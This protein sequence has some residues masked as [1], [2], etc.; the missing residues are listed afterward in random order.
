MYFNVRQRLPI[1]RF[2]GTREDVMHFDIALP[3]KR[4]E[5]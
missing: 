4:T 1:S 5:K 2:S 3:A